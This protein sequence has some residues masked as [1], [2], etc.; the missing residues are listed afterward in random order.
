MCVCVFCFYSM[1]LNQQRA[2]KE[3][4]SRKNEEKNPENTMWWVIKTHLINDS[5]S[6]PTSGCTFHFVIKYNSQ[7]VRVPCHVQKWYRSEKTIWPHATDVYIWQ[8]KKVSHAQRFTPETE[9]VR[10]IKTIM[11]NT[12]TPR[13]PPETSHLSET[14]STKKP[15]YISLVWSCPG[16]ISPEWSDAVVTWVFVREIRD[17]VKSPGLQCFLEINSPSHPINPA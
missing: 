1:M 2:V 15:E 16:H 13:N 17:E 4:R 14:V 7:P 12:H 8:G 9:S 5:I 3:L 10:Y 11:Y 6:L